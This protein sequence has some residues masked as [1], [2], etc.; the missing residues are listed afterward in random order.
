MPLKKYPQSLE[1]ED[2]LCSVALLF[3]PNSND[4]GQGL[5]TAKKKR[6]KHTNTA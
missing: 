1:V 5:Y 6:N 2:L 3:S 4:V